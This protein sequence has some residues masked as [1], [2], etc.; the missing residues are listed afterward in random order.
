MSLDIYLLT[1]GKERGE[2][3]LLAVD[4]KLPEQRKV[5]SFEAKSEEEARE[6]VAKLNER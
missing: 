4:S 3:K 5:L 6:F 2:A 1:F